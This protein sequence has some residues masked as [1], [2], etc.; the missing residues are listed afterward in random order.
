MEHSRP[1]RLRPAVRSPEET[2]MARLPYLDQSDLAPEDQDLLKRGIALHRALVNSP[3]AARAMGGLGQY[4]RYGAKLDPRLR[5]LAILQI[6]W[7][8][9]SPYEWSHHVKIGF[10]FG[11]TDADLPALI[12]ES[13]GEATALEPLARL[14]LQAAREVYAGPGIA[15]PT[16]AALRAGLPADQVVD[17][18]VTA[19]FYCAVV[20]V[21]ASLEIDVEA[22]YLP[23]LRQY[24]LPL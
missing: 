23:Y 24:P 13:R 16:F 2:P 6:G 7:L 17:L 21:L 18:V 15:M 1:P 3:G 22:E 20:R 5:E 12:A 11:V 4:I 14:V 10:D 8:A 9:R 19:S